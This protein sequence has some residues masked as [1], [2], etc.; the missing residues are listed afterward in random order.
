MASKV[1]SKTVVPRNFH[2]LEAINK[3]GNVTHVTFGLIDEALD[4]KKYNNNFTKMEHF[5]GTMM[6]DDGE[7]MNIFEYTIHCTK[8][9]PKE[10]PLITFA[11]HCLEHRRLKKVCSANGCLIEPVLAL[12]K[13]DETTLL[14]DYLTNVL[15]VIA[16]FR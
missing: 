14:G 2:L 4:E 8:N 13:S 12:I 11:P 1:S 3:A 5:N 16:T 10:R 6:Y 7:N 15:H 9:Y